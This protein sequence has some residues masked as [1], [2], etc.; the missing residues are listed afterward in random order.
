MGRGSAVT[1]NHYTERFFD[2]P[3][4]EF[5]HGDRR[6]GANVVHRLMLGWEDE[7]VLPGE[8]LEEFLRQGDPAALEALII[9]PWHD[10]A[11]RPPDEYLLGLTGHRLPQLRALFVGDMTREDCEISWI[12][13]SD[14]SDLIDVYPHL[15]VLRVRGGN[16][17]R[18]PRTEYP[19]LR[20]LVI[21]TGGLPRSVM[22]AIADSR[23]PLLQRL[24]LWLGMEEY[25]FDGDLATVTRL[26]E[27]IGPQRLTHLGLRDSEITDE[28]AVYLAQ[29]D[30]VGRL[31]T[32]DLSM[33]TLSDRG[34]EA[35]CSSRHLT[36]LKVLDVRHHYISRPIIRQLELL[37]LTLR[38]DRPVRI[39]SG[40]RRYV[41]V[42]E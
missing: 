20:Q 41:Q 3:V 38:I 6:D 5:R 40:D 4:V 14:Y 25:G 10:A 39:R 24:E 32:L 12:R 1:V 31:H 7:A 13:Q 33:G 11:G 34:A 42:G 29:Q 35:L 37:P 22:E 23:L 26:L 30:W 16:G 9:G 21:E 15:E 27:G 18:L 28:L 8:L 19:E 2:R 17:L 36:G